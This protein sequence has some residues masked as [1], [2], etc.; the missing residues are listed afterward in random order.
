MGVLRAIAAALALGPGALAAQEGEVQSE[1]RGNE[2]PVAR[3]LW[4]EETPEGVLQLRDY[5][6]F[7]R[8]EVRVRGSRRGAASEG[9][10]R[11][12]RY[13]FGGNAGG[14][15]I[16]MTAP[17]AQAPE[18]DGTWTVAFVMPRAHSMDDLPAPNDPAVR[19]MRD[20]G[21][22][23]LS[24]GF[25]GRWDAD[26]LDRRAD[27]LLAAARERGLTPAGTPE[28]LFYDGPMTPAFRRRNEVSVPV[29]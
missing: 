28:Y 18:G 6:P 15:R 9:F 3:V 10:R 21:G 19:L 8:A 29:R 22:R 14:E 7:L 17:V 11:V 25:A 27:A 23:R 5:A 13:I 20:P 24:L 1:W 12:A 16:A 2:V 4:S 26:G